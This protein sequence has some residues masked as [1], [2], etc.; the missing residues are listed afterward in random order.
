MKGKTLFTL[1]KTFDSYVCSSLGRILHPKK[2][3]AETSVSKSFLT[4]FQFSKFC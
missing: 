1:I 4:P 2:D 3:S